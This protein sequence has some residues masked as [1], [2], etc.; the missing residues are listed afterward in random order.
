MKPYSIILADDHVLLRQGLKRILE[1]SEDLRIVGE[2]GDGLELLALVGKVPA[3]MIILDI[4]M[5]NLGGIEAASSIRKKHPRIKV[6]ILT[7]HTEEEY[8]SL[9]ISSK[10]DGYLLKENADTELFSA[11]ERIRQ[12]KRYI[13]PVLSEALAE[14]LGGRGHEQSKRGTLSAR[15]KEIMWL[16]A[17]GKKNKEIADILSLSTRTVEHHRANI[18]KKLNLK[19]PADLVRYA[20]HE[21]RSRHI[22]GGG[23]RFAG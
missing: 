1:D 9:A 7:M 16:I 14:K 3:D 19:A 17:T 10:V 5:P 15:E 6:L 20:L 11:I 21:G 23:R 4:S 13:S 8:L 18:M 2:A 22:P 12:G